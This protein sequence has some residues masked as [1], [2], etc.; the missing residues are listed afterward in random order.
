MFLVMNLMSLVVDLMSL[1]VHL[2]SQVVDLG[3]SSCRFGIHRR[4]FDV[5]SR[6][7]TPYGRHRGQL[8]KDSYL[9]LG[10][11]LSHFQAFCLS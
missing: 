5:C 8:T 4:G 1:V 11:V 9:I 3:V 2:M 6:D 7:L 10:M